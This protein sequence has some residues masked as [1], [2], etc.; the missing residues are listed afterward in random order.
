MTLEQERKLIEAFHGMTA[1]TPADIKKIKETLIKKEKPI[2][3]N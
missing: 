2:S 3:K 1:L